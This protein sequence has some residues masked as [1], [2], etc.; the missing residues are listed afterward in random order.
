MGLPF[1]RG[2]KAWMD[3]DNLTIGRVD[4][5]RLGWENGVPN[6]VTL[7]PKDATCTESCSPV[8][9]PGTRSPPG[10]S[11][12]CCDRSPLRQL[13]QVML[14]RPQ[15]QRQVAFL[16]ERREGRVQMEAKTGEMQLQSKEFRGHQELEE[17]RK[18][19]PLEPLEDLQPRDT[20]ITDFQP[21]ELPRYKVEGKKCCEF[22]LI[23][24]LVSH[25]GTLKRYLMFKKRSQ[26]YLILCVLNA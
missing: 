11:W 14:H 3:L 25:T 13:I 5:S 23:S 9:R 20:L 7:F 1:G 16:G 12:L 22:S 4:S 6:L 17:A 15:T 18:A 10:G 8:G 2:L 26:Y 21:P 19:P 24:I